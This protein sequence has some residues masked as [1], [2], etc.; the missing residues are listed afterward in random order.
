MKKK[1]NK[2]NPNLDA[3]QEAAESL[4]DGLEELYLKRGMILSEN[5]EMRRRQLADFFMQRIWEMDEDGK[6]ELAK[7]AENESNPQSGKGV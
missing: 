6:R 2:S 1:R 4:L 7:N 3:R 5:L